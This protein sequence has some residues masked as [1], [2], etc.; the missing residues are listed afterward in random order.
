MKYESRITRV[1][2][3]PEG[4]SLFSEHGYHASIEDE[5]AGEFVSVKSESQGPT[6]DMQIEPEV[7]PILRET[8]DAMFADIKQREESP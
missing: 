2:I 4:E 7:W 1:S 6:N 8:I 3:I 5:A